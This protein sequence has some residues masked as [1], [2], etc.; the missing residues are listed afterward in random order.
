MGA[1]NRTFNMYMN[2]AKFVQQIQ[3]TVI[4]QKTNK[5]GN[6]MFQS[7]AT[8][9]KDEVKYTSNSLWGQKKTKI[10]SNEDCIYILGF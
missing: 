8:T 4:E 2:D 5:H 6:T 1:I 3:L 9:D 7:M 10:Y